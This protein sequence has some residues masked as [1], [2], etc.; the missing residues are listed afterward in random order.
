[1]KKT[2]E[3]LSW[4]ALCILLGIAV[5][6]ISFQISMKPDKG[7]EEEIRAQAEQYLDKNFNQEF[8]IYDTLYDNLGNF[9]FDYAAKVRNKKN[10][11]E[12]L[13][14]MDDETKEMV[15][16]YVAD[17]WADELEGDIQYYINQNFGENADY[18]VYFPDEIGMERGIDP[19]N[20]GSYK[21]HKVS[22]TIRITLP[23]KKREGDHTLFNEF[24]S[25][26][27]SNLK[28]QQGT[29]NVGYVAE[30]G[31]ILEEDEWS[32]EY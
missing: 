23:R 28:L 31:E 27:E 2:L 30:N 29:V 7:K 13:V 12:F 16:T 26:L 25:F 17:H 5:L 3:I 19:I 32:K 10:Q 22:S 20:P 21:D 14:Y 24:V 15:D 11:T 9:E 18:Y 8:E 6:V 4:L 1:M